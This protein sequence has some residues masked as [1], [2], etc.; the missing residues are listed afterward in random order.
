[1]KIATIVPVFIF[2]FLVNQKSF[3]QDVGG[4]RFG[5]QVSYGNPY[6]IPSYADGAPSYS[7]RYFFD[8]GFLYLKTLSDKWEFETGLLYSNTQ[9]RVT[10]T[11][12]LGTS[13]PSYND[14]M[15]QWIIPANLRVWLPKR[16]LLQFG[17]NLS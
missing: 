10:P 12:P 4:S 6:Y 11:F 8:I 14:A 1:M 7:G 2:V 5:L 16:F 17:P 13:N 9:F 15:N 3:A